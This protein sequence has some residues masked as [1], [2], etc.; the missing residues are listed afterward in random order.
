MTM[1]IYIKKS[2]HPHYQ[3]KNFL[4]HH[5]SQEDY[6][7]TALKASRRFILQ[8]KSSPCKKKPPRLKDPDN[9]IRDA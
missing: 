2:L 5:I 9:S 4:C 3:M 6:S 8:H 7:N 1:V